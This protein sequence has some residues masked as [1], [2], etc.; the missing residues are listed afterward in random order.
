MEPYHIREGTLRAPNGSPFLGSAEYKN[1]ESLM[2]FGEVFEIHSM[3]HEA[4]G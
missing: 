4:R 3:R 2:V 1:T